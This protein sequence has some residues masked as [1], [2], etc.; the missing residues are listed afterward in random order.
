[1]DVKDEVMRFSFLLSVS[2]VYYAEHFATFWGIESLTSVS[3]PRGTTDSA[4][5]WG[6][7]TSWHVIII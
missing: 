1:V 6:G 4:M 2:S 3:S 5:G 7:V